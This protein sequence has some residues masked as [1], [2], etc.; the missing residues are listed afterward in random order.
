MFLRNYHSVSSKPIQCSNAA[1]CMHHWYSGRSYCHAELTDTSC[2][3]CQTGADLSVGLALALKRPVGGQPALTCTAIEA[4]KHRGIQMGAPRSR[5]HPYHDCQSSSREC[6]WYHGCGSLSSFLLYAVLTLIVF[7]EYV[8][9]GLICWTSQLIP[10]V[11]K[12]YR[13]KSTEGL[14]ST[15][16]CAKV[17]PFFYPIHI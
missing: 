17:L 13:N 8:L 5:F 15:L 7:N 11:W 9:T 1:G 6:L 12:V 10:Q 14:A 2:Q 16:L 3:T 4:P